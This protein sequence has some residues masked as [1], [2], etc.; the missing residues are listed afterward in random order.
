MR[1]QLLNYFTATQQE[2]LLSKDGIEIA[3]A[4]EGTSL[5]NRIAQ[6]DNDADF[7]SH[8]LKFSSEVPPEL[9]EIKYI[10]HPVSFTTRHP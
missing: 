10:R 3:P 7:R 2:R 6:I 4:N 5:R 9:G 1:L 8:I